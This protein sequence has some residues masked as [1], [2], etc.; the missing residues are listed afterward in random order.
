M[1]AIHETTEACHAVEATDT[2]STG[3][4][5][6]AADHVSA[7]TFDLAAADRTALGKPPSV[8]QVFRLTAQV[9]A[10][11]RERRAVCF[12]FFDASKADSTAGQPPAIKAE[13]TC[14]MAW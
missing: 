10:K 14:S 11:F 9:A 3:L 13:P 7:G 1:V 6:S 2:A 5:R 4:F 8:F 12:A